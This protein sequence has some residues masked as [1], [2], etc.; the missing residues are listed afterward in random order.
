M[1]IFELHAFPLADMVK[2]S[3]NGARGKSE[4]EILFLAEFERL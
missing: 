2:E 4:L 3:L 1:N